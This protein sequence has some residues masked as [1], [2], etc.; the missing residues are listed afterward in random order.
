MT[1][2]HYV[3]HFIFHHFIICT[4]IHFALAY[5]AKRVMRGV[6]AFVEKLFLASLSVVSFSSL[7]DVFDI[8]RKLKVLATVSA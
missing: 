3:E 2:L 1:I 4:P 8:R 7:V 5:L 6:G